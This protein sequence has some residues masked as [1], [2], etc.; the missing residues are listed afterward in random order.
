[1]NMRDE[2]D[3]SLRRRRRSR[4]GS[5]ALKTGEI[6]FDLPRKPKKVQR[7]GG[8]IQREELYN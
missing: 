7:L 8:A 1:M 4:Y 2:D 5:A 6:L 3:D